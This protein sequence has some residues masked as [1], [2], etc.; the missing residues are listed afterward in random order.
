MSKIINIGVISLGQ[1]GAHILGQLASMPEKAKIAAV[2]DLSPH[3]D[4]TD[5]YRLIDRAD[6]DAVIIASTEES[7]IS[8]P[9]YAMNKGKAVGCLGGTYSVQQCLELVKTYEKTKTPIMFL[10]NACYEDRLMAI[11]RMVKAGFFGEIVHCDCDYGQS[12][13]PV[14]Q[15]LNINRGNRF[16]SIAS[17][18]SSQE[19]AVTSVITC[20]NGET[21]RLH[22]SKATVRPYCQDVNIYG[23]KSTYRSDVKSFFEGR[24]E[25]RD[26]KNSWYKNR[27]NEDRFIE[28]WRDPRWKEYK[29]LDGKDWLALCDFVDCL[30][31]DK[32]MPID[33]YDMASLMAV[34]TLSK[35]STQNGSEVVAFPDFT[36][37]RWLYDKA[38]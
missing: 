10:E 6:V 12:L 16:V 26:K 36:N 25:E 9:V 23:T 20:A 37:G 5:A 38:F 31:E 35:R 32:P 22:L 21:I 27:A 29:G 18:A 7:D 8:L 30:I 1:C 14:A 33:V 17:F 2:C 24:K 28:E 3:K 34:T 19:G 11:G 13:G 4:K 15:Y